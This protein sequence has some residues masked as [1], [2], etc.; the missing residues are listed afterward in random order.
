MSYNCRESSSGFLFGI[1]WAR[2]KPFS[3]YWVAAPA[4]GRLLFADA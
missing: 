2:E 4:A 3:H 1:R